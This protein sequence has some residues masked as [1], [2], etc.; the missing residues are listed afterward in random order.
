MYMST[1]TGHWDGQLQCWW[2]H[3]QYGWWYLLCAAK[4]RKVF[5]RSLTNS[6][7]HIALTRYHLTTGEHLPVLMWMGHVQCWTTP[8]NDELW[9]NDDVIVSCTPSSSLLVSEYREALQS[10]LKASMP[11]S[12][13]VNNSGFPIGKGS[14]DLE[15][16]VASLISRELV[17]CKLLLISPQA[18]LTA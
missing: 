15:E 10:R 17:L 4:M 8:G 7:M 1:P 9:C 6:C 14:S 11:T 12:G 2:P 3:F 5:W 18:V 16:E 13:W